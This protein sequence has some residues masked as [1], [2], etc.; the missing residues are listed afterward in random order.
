[1]DGRSFLFLDTRAGDAAE[2]LEQRASDRCIGAISH[3]VH[4]ERGGCAVAARYDE[5]SGEL[6]MREIA[7]FAVQ[8][9]HGREQRFCYS[10]MNL[11]GGDA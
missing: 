9:A 6:G 5:R 11:G 10:S 7:H 8:W 2:F 3:A 4:K 1:M